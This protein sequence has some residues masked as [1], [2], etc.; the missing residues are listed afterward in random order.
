[1]KERNQ[2]GA[3]VFSRDSPHGLRVLLVTSRE[4]GRW[5]IP[6]GWPMKAL[7]PHQAAA[8]EAYEEA[9]VEG[10]ISKKAIG[11][12]RYP[13]VLRNGD[14]VTCRVK[15]FPLEVKRILGAWP[16]ADERRRQWFDAREAAN[17][18]AETGLASILE[19]LEDKI[20]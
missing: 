3:I 6:K 19:E 16:E 20:A 18:V 11:T 4:T 15:V 8:R 1:M 7:R 9:G 2:I 17:A 12:Y 13:K 10:D 5:V 14:V